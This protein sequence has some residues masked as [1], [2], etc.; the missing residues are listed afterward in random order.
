MSRSWRTSIGFLL[1]ATCGASYL[2][3]GQS[4]SADRMVSDTSEVIRAR[5]ENIAGYTVTERAMPFTE[6]ARLPQ[7][8]KEP[9]GLNMRKT[10]GLATR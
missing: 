7:P 1:L 9:S 3:A 4:E 2:P 6:M 8:L 10:K 5:F